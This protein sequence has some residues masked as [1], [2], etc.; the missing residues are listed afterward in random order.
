MLFCTLFNFINLQVNRIFERSREFKLRTSLGAVKKNLF[1]Q[2]IIEISIQVLLALLVGVSL[3]ELTTPYI[4]QLLDTSIQKQE[5]FIDLLQTGIFGWTLLLS[6]VLLI[7]SRFI[8]RQSNDFKAGPQ[9]FH[10][11]N[12]EWIRKISIGLQLGIC[13]GF[14][15]TAQIL[16]LQINR[17]KNTAMGFDTD[18]LIQV[19]ISS[20]IYSQFTDEIK[21]IPSIT[22]CIRGGN[23]RLS[24]DNWHTEKEIG[25]ENKPANASYE[26]QMIQA[27]IDF[28]QKMKITLLKGRYLE[29]TDMQSDDP[30]GI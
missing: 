14:M 19:N 4:E 9:L 3:I 2:I 6:I 25:W 30:S 27:G 10:T 21:Q 7:I 16:F 11:A 24:H 8:H 26:I 12:N 20:Q 23:F 15:F 22:D 18:N 13:V 29:D 28:A 17:M 1:C 5:L